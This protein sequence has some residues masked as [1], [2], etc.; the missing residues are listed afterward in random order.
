MVALF[1][2]LPLLKIHS[3][4]QLNHCVVKYNLNVIKSIWMIKNITEQG[5]FWLAMQQLN[6][7]LVLS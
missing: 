6:S 7:L 3:S 5:R 1:K 2:I 4:L